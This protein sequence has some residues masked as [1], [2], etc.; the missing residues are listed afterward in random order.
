MKTFSDVAPYSWF[1]G[2]ALGAG[3]YVLIC[4]SE[5]ASAEPVP[6]PVEV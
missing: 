3:L 4:R 2:T 5:R 6:E 1:I